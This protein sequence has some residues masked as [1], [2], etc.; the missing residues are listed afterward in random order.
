[1]NCGDFFSWFWGNTARFLCFLSLYFLC[2][3][4]TLEV[5]FSYIY[6]IYTIFHIY[7]YN[8]VF[9]L[10]LPFFPSLLVAIRVPGIISLSI[11]SPSLAYAFHRVGIRLCLFLCLIATGL[12]FYVLYYIKFVNLFSRGARKFMIASVCQLTLKISLTTWSFIV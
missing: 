6:N 3:L 7:I 12:V 1:M 9:S 2:L 11:S 5:F 4:P 8:F 10:P